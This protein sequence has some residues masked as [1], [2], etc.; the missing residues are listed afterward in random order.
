M[1][2]ELR[3]DGAENFNNGWTLDQFMNK[4]PKLSKNTIFIWVH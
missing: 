2:M 1:L 4:G 3:F